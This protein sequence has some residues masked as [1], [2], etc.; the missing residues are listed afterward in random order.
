MFWR[1]SKAIV[2]SECGKPIEPGESR[3]VD[4]NRV[5]KVELHRHLHCQKAARAPQTNSARP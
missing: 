1:T 2:C 3:F 4:K 5:T